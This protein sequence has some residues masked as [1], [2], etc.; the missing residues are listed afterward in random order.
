MLSAA[1]AVEHIVTVLL[2][3]LLVDRTRT[4]WLT[5][6]SPHNLSSFK[7]VESSVAA[8]AEHANIVLSGDI[9][10]R[11]HSTARLQIPLILVSSPHTPSHTARST[12]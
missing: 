8:Y 4:A 11:L 2:V 7:C 12:G 10:W 1:S 9:A 5:T 6:I 3:N